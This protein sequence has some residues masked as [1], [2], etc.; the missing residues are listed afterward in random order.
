MTNEPTMGRE[1]PPG[2]AAGLMWRETKVTRGGLR[3]RVQHDADLRRLAEISYPFEACG[4]LIGNSVGADD[5]SQVE[6]VVHA[7]N[8]H[9][10][11]AQDRYLLDPEDFLAT[12]CAARSQ[13]LEIVGIWHSHPNSTAEPSII[14]LEAAWQGYSYVIVAVDALGHSALR[15]WRLAGPQFREEAVLVR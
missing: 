14:D 10:T 2:H 9:P 15:S 12:D 1:A 11:R 4:L 6:Q 8:L 3:L 5:G 7:L 13:G